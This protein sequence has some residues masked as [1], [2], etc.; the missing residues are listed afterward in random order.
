MVNSAAARSVCACVVGRGR[1]G[2]EELL[3]A[4]LALIPHRLTLTRYPLYHPVVFAAR[5]EAHTLSCSDFSRALSIPFGSA[6]VLFFFYVVEDSF[7]EADGTS[8]PT[9]SNHF[10][11]CKKTFSRRR[12]RL[13]NADAG[14][15]LSIRSF[16]F[17]FVRVFFS[18]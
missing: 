7:E 10:S 17:L 13:A 14:L 3:F 18:L 15:P 2:R 16:V 4:A 11:L 12:S 5:G 8:S 9:L 6:R 1:E